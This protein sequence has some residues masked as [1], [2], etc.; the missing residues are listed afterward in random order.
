MCQFALRVGHLFDLQSL[1][2]AALE[3]FCRNKM[4]VRP[5]I[6]IEGEDCLAL[7]IFVGAG[8]QGIGGLGHIRGNACGPRV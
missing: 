5:C 6:T 3:H 2:M 7:L 4:T 1:T 8:K